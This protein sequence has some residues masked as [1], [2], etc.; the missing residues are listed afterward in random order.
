MY[1]IDLQFKS[2]KDLLVRALCARI[3][4]LEG[5]YMR[6]VNSMP[7]YA[8]K[9]S[10]RIKESVRVYS[11]IEHMQFLFTEPVV[12]KLVYGDKSHVL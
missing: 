5:V 1:T 7:E 10:E 9:V 4:D 8:E 12:S 2:D 3:I 11:D 6:V